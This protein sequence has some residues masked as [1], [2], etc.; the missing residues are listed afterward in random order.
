MGEKSYRFLCAS[1]V[2]AVLGLV[3][4]ASSLA[5]QGDEL[6]PAEQ[7][8]LELYDETIRRVTA[9]EE[10]YLETIRSLTPAEA[11]Y[12]ELF[13]EASR[14]LTPA[15]AKYL[16]LIRERIGATNAKDASDGPAK[17]RTPKGSI[18]TLSPCDKEYKKGDMIV[19][20]TISEIEVTAD[21]KFSYEFLITVFSTDPVTKKIV[22]TGSAFV[23]LMPGQKVVGFG[24]SGLHMNAQPGTFDV[25]A[26]LTVRRTDKKEF[27]KLDSEPNGDLKACSYTVK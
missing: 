18:K 22:A 21:D 9:A 24:T 2:L 11:K 19:V 27:T 15:E 23:T 10:K 17:S 14:G 12:L 7:K 16:E 13:R 26:L 1:C 25:S 4:L 8:Y 20:S 6:R 5:A 3:F